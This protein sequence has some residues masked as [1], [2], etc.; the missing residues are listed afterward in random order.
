MAKL[1]SSAALK[2]PRSTFAGRLPNSS[3]EVTI[4][5]MTEAR[6]SLDLL[7]CFFKQNR[8]IP[9]DDGA[10]CVVCLGTCQVVVGLA[11]CRWI[12]PT[13][14]SR[15]TLSWSLSAHNGPGTRV[16]TAFPAISQQTHE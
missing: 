13:S 16:Q 15:P 5:P 1:A 10:A 8:L 7:R 3:G 4:K 9:Q 12:G 2:A 6:R 14:S 11:G